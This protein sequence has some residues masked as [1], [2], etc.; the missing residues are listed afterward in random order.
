MDLFRFFP[1]FCFG[2]WTFGTPSVEN[3]HPGHTISKQTRSKERIQK[4]SS[5]SMKI[6]QR[7]RGEDHPSSDTWLITM[8]IVR[9]LSRVVPL[10]NG[11]IWLIN[12]GGLITNHFL[13]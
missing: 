13:A 9:P 12:A 8:V 3:K 10:P 7:L 1:F 6:P 5:P 11:L 2:I 4:A